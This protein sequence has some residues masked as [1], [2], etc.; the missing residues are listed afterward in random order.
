VKHVA[1][2]VRFLLDAYLVK[3]FKKLALLTE[4]PDK[5]FTLRR[6]TALQPLTLAAMTYLVG[7]R[8]QAR[9]HESEAGA[10]SA[11]RLIDAD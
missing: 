2:E 9:L 11:L 5:T 4:T 7:N 6:Y 3:S 10:T 8:H 1:H